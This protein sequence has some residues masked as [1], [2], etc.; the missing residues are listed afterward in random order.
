MDRWTMGMEMWLMPW[1]PNI[2]ITGRTVF[3]VSMEVL[4]GLGGSEGDLF[5]L[6]DGS[7]MQA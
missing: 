4:R 7:R 6:K 3:K 5:S 1:R 2:V